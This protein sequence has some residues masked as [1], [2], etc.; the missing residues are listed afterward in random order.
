M[1]KIVVIL[2]DTHAGHKL[3]LMNPATV[4]WEDA[5]G[6]AMQGRDP[7]PYHPSLTISQ[8]WLWDCY[9]EDLCNV[10]ALADGDPLYV[11]HNGDI[12]WGSKYPN[13]LV[14][15]TEAA[16]VE[17]ARWN[18]Q[19]WLELENLQAVRIIHGTE[20]HEFGRGSAARLVVSGLNAWEPNLDAT[21]LRH[22]LFDVDG[23]KIDCAHHGPTTGI[24]N[25][26]QGNQLRYYLRSLMLDE[27][28]AGRMPPR[29]VVRSHFHDF[30]HEWVEVRGQSPDACWEADIL[31]TPAYAMMT[32]YATQA[33]RSAYLQAAGLVALEIVDGELAGIHPFWRRM[34]LRTE[35]RL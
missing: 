7:A 9:Q 6:A 29:V 24:R 32:H 25:W 2:S 23:V 31:V 10:A 4:L 30:A 13:N 16:Q 20:S 5:I 22:G 33:T 1:R 21:E 34:D 28:I 12:T 27:I 18:L 35:E 8:R 26:T 15:D 14:D 19:P 11:I 17:I 3:A